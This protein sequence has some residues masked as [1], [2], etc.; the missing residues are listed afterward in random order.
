MNDQFFP[1]YLY[2][3]TALGKGDLSVGR[4][5]LQFTLY[6]LKMVDVDSYSNILKT[7]DGN[8]PVDGIKLAMAFSGVDVTLFAVK[9]DENQFLENGLTG[10]PRNT[11]GTFNSIG[12]N[13]VGGLNSLID[14]TAGLRLASA[15]RSASRSALPT[16][17]RGLRPRQPMY[18][19]MSGIR[20][21]FTASTRLFRS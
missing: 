2:I 10:Q 8:Y 18:S 13:A 21:R 14:Q 19:A 7:S 1:Y 3:N 12:G 5:P 20:R 6:T 4:F 11:I 9:N 15:R 17:R 16:I